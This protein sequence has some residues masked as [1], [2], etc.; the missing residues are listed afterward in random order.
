[1]PLLSR[2]EAMRLSRLLSSSVGAAALTACAPNTTPPRLM[3]EVPS[4][5]R[6]ACPRPA[7][8]DRPTVGELAGFSIEQ[9]AAISVCDARRSAAVAIADAAGEASAPVVKHSW[10]R[11]W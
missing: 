9:E 7:R 11:I 3:V 1:M 10:W 5:L 8:P 6:E 4:M 2:R